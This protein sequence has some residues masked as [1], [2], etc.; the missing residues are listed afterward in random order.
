MKDEQKTLLKKVEVSSERTQLLESDVKSIEDTVQTNHRQLKA[1]EST[2]TTLQTQ[3]TNTATRVSCN[4]ELTKQLLSNQKFDKKEIDRT[5]K[6]HTE[7]IQRNTSAVE[8]IALKQDKTGKDVAVLNTTVVE[9]KSDV[10]LIKEDV[11]LIR[12]ES[13]NAGK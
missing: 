12:Q 11:Q 1:V 2:V 10:Q 4:I 6:D 9:I 8:Q 7:I 13:K 3:Q 5:F